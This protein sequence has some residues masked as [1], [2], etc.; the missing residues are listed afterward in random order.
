MF[1][2]TIWFGRK[3]DNMLQLMGEE[4]MDWMKMT[5]QDVIDNLFAELKRLTEIECQS[6]PYE[7]RETELPAG[8]DEDM[9]DQC[10]VIA[11]RAMI[12]TDKL[13]LKK[14]TLKMRVVQ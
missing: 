5:R 1:P 13:R 9:V 2:S 12:L 10:I 4:R 6:A 3:M 14:Q 11:V 7:K 8:A